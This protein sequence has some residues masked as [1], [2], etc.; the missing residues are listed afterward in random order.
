MGLTDCLP[1]ALVS[2]EYWTRPWYRDPTYHAFL[3][4]HSH[5]ALPRS[6]L[7]LPPSTLRLNLILAA[8]KHFDQNLSDWRG[9]VS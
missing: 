2:S 3:P 9:P 8:A 1:V 7:L 4:V 6:C 5:A